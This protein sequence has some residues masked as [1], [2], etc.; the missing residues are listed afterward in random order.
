MWR[1]I[2]LLSN[3]FLCLRNIIIFFQFLHFFFRGYFLSIYNNHNIPLRN[4]DLLYSLNQSCLS[5]LTIFELYV[6][7]LCY[8]QRNR[9]NFNNV[10]YLIIFIQ[11]I[12]LLLNILIYWNE[13]NLF[14]WIDIF[15]WF[16]FLKSFWNIENIIWRFITI[17]LLVDVL[18]TLEHFRVILIFILKFN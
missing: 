18:V 1:T 7:F 15:N 11:I 9:L 4:W 14:H 10:E 12:L 13:I 2:I 6:I 17:W 16:N 5:F 3:D 8:I